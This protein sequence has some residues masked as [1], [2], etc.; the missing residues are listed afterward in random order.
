MSAFL[1]EVL[2]KYPRHISS[3]YVFCGPDGTSSHD[4]RTSSES[5]LKKAALPH[6]RIH[7]LRHTFASHLVMA[8]VDIPTVQKL[9]GNK[10]IQTTMRYAHLAPGHLKAAV[11]RLSFYSQRDTSAQ[12]RHCPNRAWFLSDFSYLSSLKG[13]ST[14]QVKS[15]YRSLFTSISGIGSNAL[16]PS[17]G[18]RP[19]KR[20]CVTVTE[21]IIL[22]NTRNG[23][24]TP[25]GHQGP[26]AKKST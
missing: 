12:P 3:P 5:T 20:S 15:V 14:S 1:Y 7:D 11:E 10:T 9:M 17:N 25:N 6:I 24:W 2:R 4:I 26:K 22:L 16:Y 19:P 13:G 8:G 18:S 21:L 23:W